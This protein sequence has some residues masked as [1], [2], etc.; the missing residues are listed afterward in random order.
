MPRRQSEF[1]LK[2]LD[3][4][5]GYS[6][7]TGFMLSIFIFTGIDVSETGILISVLQAVVGVL[8]SVS[9]LVLIISILVAIVEVV[10]IINSIMRISEHGYSGVI[11]STAGF[12]G[13]LLVFAGAMWNI[14]I[15]TYIG[16]AML[17]GGVIVVRIGDG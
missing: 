4:V 13:A 11:V 7:F 8:G 16:I 15:V 6:V 14:P 17:A 1:N 10:V 12:F 3:G 9:N 2:R 5:F